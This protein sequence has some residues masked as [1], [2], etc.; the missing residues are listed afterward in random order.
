MYVCVYIICPPFCDSVKE[1]V[2]IN[3]LVL[4]CCIHN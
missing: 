3:I 4:L 2:K 1:G